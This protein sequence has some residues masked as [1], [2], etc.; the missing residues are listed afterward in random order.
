MELCDICFENIKDTF[1]YGLFGDFKLVI[2]KSTGYFNATKLCERGGK[3]FRNWRSLEKSEKMV[4]YYEKSWR[5]DSS[6]S[7]LYEVKLQNNDRLNKLVTGTYVPK[8]LI[9]DIASWVS[10][11]FYDKCNRIV[12]DYFVEET[13]RKIEHLQIELQAKE[14]ELQVKD[15]QHKAELQVKDEQEG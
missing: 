1:Y 11:E 5:L 3:R 6:A 4:E 10:I 14:T 2:D 8:E 13:R 15:E 9:L 12:V 7:F